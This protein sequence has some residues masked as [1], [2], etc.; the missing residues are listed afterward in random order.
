[1]FKQLLFPP[2]FEDD[3]ER[4]RVAR[5]LHITLLVIFVVTCLGAPVSLLRRPSPALSMRLAIL[6]AIIGIAYTLLRLRHVRSAAAFYTT[7]QWVYLTAI[8]VYSGGV[9][10]PNRTAYVVSVVLA[11]LLL[12]TRAALLFGGLSFV[13]AIAMSYIE[14]VWGLPTPMEVDFTANLAVLVNALATVTTLVVVA[15]RSLNEALARA[16]QYAAELEGQRGQLER[17]VDERTQGLETAR[18]QAENARQEAEAA[19]QELRARIWQVTGMAALHEC[20]HGEQD[21]PT[22]A[23]NVIRH[24]C[25]TIDAPVGALYVLEGETLEL[26]GGYAYHPR[27][28]HATRFELCEGLVGQAAREETLRC[29]TDVP[30]ETLAIPSVA[31][32]VRPRHVVLLPLRHWKH[33]LGVVEIGLLADLPPAHAEFLESAA[34]AI[35]N[36]F[37]TALN[38]ARIQELL[39]QTQQQAEELRV[40]EEELRAANEELEAQAQALQAFLPTGGR[41]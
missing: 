10:S 11:G 16:R 25:R 5:V 28:D 36:A 12:G 22:L 15:I 34:A 20:M 7:A 24:L 23:G 19:N 3:A 26:A 9:A 37:D 8:M 33:V 27:S 30:A 40:Q 39:V 1:M 6:L 17:M 18:Q 35:A 31:G 4:T 38:R 13:S 29:L 14:A 21:V 41:E 32:Q 2:V